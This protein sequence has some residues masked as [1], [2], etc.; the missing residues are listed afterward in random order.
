VLRRLDSPAFCFILSAQS[1]HTG[2]VYRAVLRNIQPAAGGLARAIFRPPGLPGGILRAFR[3]HYPV[4]IPPPSGAPAGAQ[5][6]L[7]LAI[8]RRRRG[9]AAAWAVHGLYNGVHTR[10]A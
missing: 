9:V 7:F 4:C 3:A 6:A 10:P 2:A 5:Y 1:F 8:P